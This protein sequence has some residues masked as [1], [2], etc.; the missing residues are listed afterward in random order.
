MNSLA[1][2]RPYGEGANTAA[3]IRERGWR[4][5]IV[6]TVELKPR[7]VG[8]VSDEL[9]KEFS[10]GIPDWIVFMSPRS[11]GMFFEAANHQD[12]LKR[13]ILERSRIMAV[14]PKTKSSLK[15]T[16][17]KTVDTPRDYSS[18]GIAEFFSKTKSQGK[19][20]LLARSNQASDLLEERL[21]AQGAVVSTL[22]LYDSSLP[23][24]ERSVSE[25][26]RELKAGNINATLFTSALSAAN[27]F[28]M[29]EAHVDAAELRRL[30]RNTLVGAIGPVTSE[31][32][33]LLGVNPGLVPDRFLIEEGIANIIDAVEARA[34]AVS[35]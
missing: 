9:E 27:L 3:Q 30:L 21:K 4:P 7:P 32:L 6:H 13:P 22:K 16:G 19:R 15:Q 25:F 28:T 29:G 24:D 2:T 26:L 17:A 33:I 10:T 14:G 8:Q 34:H 35:H 18:E 11:T 20:I 1:V 12:G 23:S 31:R 5:L